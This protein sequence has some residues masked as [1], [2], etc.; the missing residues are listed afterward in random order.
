M[1]PW[2]RILL[3]ILVATLG[4]FSFILIVISKNKNILSFVLYFSISVIVMII[5]QAIIA[6]NFV[7]AFIVACVVSFLGVK[8]V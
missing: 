5:L 7:L 3:W 6:N 1:E 2:I 4:L 8:N